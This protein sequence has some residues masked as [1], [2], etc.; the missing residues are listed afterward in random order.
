MA[1]DG[2]YRVKTEYMGKKLEGTVE[3]K[4]E[5]SRVTGTVSG[6]GYTVPIQNG[7]LSGQSMSGVIEGPT[8]MGKMRAKVTAQ[9]SGDT[10]TGKLRAGL[11]GASF[12]G[13]RV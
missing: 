4:V 8:P 9:V 12:T 1:I 2:T 10:I 3:L 11:V 6:L 5:G 13:T 7:K